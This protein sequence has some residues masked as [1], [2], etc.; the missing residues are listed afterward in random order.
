MSGHELVIKLL[1]DATSVHIPPTGS[2]TPVSF[3]VE[4]H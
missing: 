4:S 1:I 3:A 2:A